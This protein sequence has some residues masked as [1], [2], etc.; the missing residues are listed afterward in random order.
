[1]TAQPSIDQDVAVLDRRGFRNALSSFPTGVTVI[2]TIGERGALIGLTANSFT[3]VSLDPPV[4]QFSLARRSPSLAAFENS[5]VFAVSILATDQGEL[6]NRFA[7][8]S[9]DK[10][11]GVDYVLG[12]D[13]GCPL[14][15]GALASFECKIHAFYDGG[16]HVIVVGYVM[17]F[18][19]LVTGEP[20]VFY[21]GS[22]RTMTPDVEF[23]DYAATGEPRVLPPLNGFDPWTAG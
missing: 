21:R 15:A 4:V 18:E 12:Q 19:R 2:S 9:N 7:T 11:S 17:R 23:T 16:D 8:P 1:M 10:W 20:L 14:I 6:S 22:Y 3:S 13:C 5:K